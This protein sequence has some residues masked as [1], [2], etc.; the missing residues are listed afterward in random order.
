MRYFLS[1]LRSNRLL[2][3][4]Y[5]VFGI[6]SAF[7]GAFT[8]SYLEEILNGFSAGTLRAERIA[9]YTG[10]L[11]IYILLNYIDNYPDIRLQNRIYLGFKLMALQ[12]M[13]TVLYRDFQSLGTGGLIQRIE[14]GATAGQNM[15]YGF[16][17]RII[18]ETL[19]AILFSLLFIYRIDP[20][21]MG[22]ILA[23]YAVVFI[24]SNLLTKY[25][26]RVKERILDNE[27]ILNN[28]L[29]RGLTEL[30]VFRTNRRFFSEYRH[31]DAAAR[32]VVD[33]KT[34]MRLI[35]E[36]FFTIFALLVIVIKAA[37]LV[38]SWRTA[39]TSVGAVAALLVL[40]DNAYTPIAI[41]N[42]LYVE[43]RLDRTAFSRYAQ[44]L[45]LRDDPRLLSGD[46]PEAIR[47]SFELRDVSVDYE[48]HK[49]LNR[50]TLTIP[51]GRFTAFVGESGSGKST[52]ARLL[53]GLLLPDAGGLLI[54]DTD[55]SKLSLDTYYRHVAYLAQE[56]PVFNG[57]LRENL[58]FDDLIPDDQLL[59]ALRAA[60]LQDLYAALPRGLD[61]VIG[62]RGQLISGGERQ[63]LALARLFLNPK[64]IVILDEAT[65]ALDNI[66]E[67]SVMRRAH[68]VLKDAT[69]ISIAHRLSTIREANEIIA[70]KSGEI[71]ERGTFDELMNAKGYFYA[72]WVAAKTKGEG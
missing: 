54:G 9:L 43:Y 61:T 32:E 66:T 26:Y 46:E 23:G 16:W 68:E 29:V 40:I 56:A 64:P 47:G 36:A 34:R 22:Y 58:A 13:R 67:E 5:L 41:F 27:E 17:L 3:A 21:I 19:P 62:E 39:N 4:A 18:R 33:H 42:V 57:T 52:I 8:A 24:I 2:T 71:V 10:A 45:D 38:V 44:F 6:I 11:A 30:V 49:A 28:F 65:S 20:G 70:M 37:I 51:E 59:K 12:K 31:A 35:H 15:L 7:L 25:L 60:E 55:M 50:L 48:G 63:R 69:V 14:N 72:L 53:A 1:I